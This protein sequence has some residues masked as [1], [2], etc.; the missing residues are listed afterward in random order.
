MTIQKML[1]LVGCLLLSSFTYANVSQS[2]AVTQT[3]NGVAALEKTTA[4]QVP[5]SPQA[6]DEDDSDDEG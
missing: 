4:P 6:D 1:C 3:G 2:H 5:G